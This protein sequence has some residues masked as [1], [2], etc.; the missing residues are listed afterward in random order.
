MPRAIQVV[1]TAP[2]E[3]DALRIAAALIDRRL[4]A[5]VQV[6][7]PLESHYTWE[8][9]RETSQE[10]LCTIKTHANRYAALERAILELH[11]YEVPEILATEVATG[12]A[13]YLKWLDSSVE[14]GGEAPMT[15]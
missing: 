14:P 7:G 13:A 10:W 6:S 11:P 12:N 9:K 2:S 5:C 3:A 1:T 15:Q 4:A 8:G